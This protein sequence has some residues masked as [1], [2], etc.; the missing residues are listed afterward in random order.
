MDYSTSSDVSLGGAA[1]E[2]Y[3]GLIDY[4]RDYRDI[5]A[6]MTETEKL[7]AFSDIQEYL[8]MLGKAG[9]SVNYARRD[10]KRVGTDWP[11]KT[12]WAVS[13]IYVVVSLKDREP[14][15][16]CVPRQVNLA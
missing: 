2:N 1:A 14:K 12:P 13:I 7:K 4:L 6:G 11:D 5:A 9:F 8:D 16:L 15:V 3:A 10:A